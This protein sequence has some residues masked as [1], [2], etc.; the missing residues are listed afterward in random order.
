MKKLLVASLPALLLAVPSGAHADGFFNA[1]GGF[2][3]RLYNQNATIGFGP[4]TL[5]AS[6]WYNYW[7]YEAHFQTPAP[8]GYPWWPA[9]QTPSPGFMP[10]A[11]A[12]APAAPA[13]PVAPGYTP[14]APT[15]VAPG[16]PQGIQPTNYYYQGIPAQ[17]P[18]YWYHR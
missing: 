8:T 15:P 5:Q 16:A 9:P 10:S 18:S 17:A 3:V 12:Y 13:A 1:Q 6:P 2:M 4:G 11:P 14:P 7:P